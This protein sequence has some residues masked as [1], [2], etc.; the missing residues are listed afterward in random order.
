MFAPQSKYK[1]FIFFLSVRKTRNKYHLKAASG[2]APQLACLLM[3]FMGGMLFRK[4]KEK[5]KKFGWQK[6]LPWLQELQNHNDR[7]EPLQ[8]PLTS[9]DTQKGLLSSSQLRDE[10]LP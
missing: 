10:H 5:K 2:P 4:E 3:Y 8:T 1:V 7:D 6:T 9:Q